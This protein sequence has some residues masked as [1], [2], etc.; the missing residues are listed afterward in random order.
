MNYIVVAVVL[1]ALLVR[2]FFSIF[3]YACMDQDTVT[4][5]MHKMLQQS[6]E[7]MQVGVSRMHLRILLYS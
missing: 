2:A 4:V 6:E 3:A 1:N 5:G 7:R